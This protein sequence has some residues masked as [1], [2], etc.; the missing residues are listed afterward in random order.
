MIPDR[1]KLMGVAI[2]IET[3][4]ASR[5]RRQLPETRYSGDRLVIDETITSPVLRELAFVKELT[6]CILNT[7]GADELVKDNRTLGLFSRLMHQ[8]LQGIIQSSQTRQTIATSPADELSQLYWEQMLADF[9]QLALKETVPSPEPYLHN[10]FDGHQTA[11]PA[12]GDCDDDEPFDFSDF[13]GSA[14][15]E[16]TDCKSFWDE[17]FRAEEPE[18]W[19]DYADSLERSNNEGW[20]YED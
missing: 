6:S 1:L 20:F 4:D 13:Y 15:C 19:I 7:V 11:A 2:R 18:T 14:V 10:P 9:E 12:V 3:G 8:A 16:E 17:Y 5:W